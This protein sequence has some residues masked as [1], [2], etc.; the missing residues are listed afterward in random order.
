MMSVAYYIRFLRVWPFWRGR[1]RK[2]S[3]IQENTELSDVLYTSQLSEPLIL[4]LMGSKD[5]RYILCKYYTWM[6]KSEPCWEAGE[7]WPSEEEEVEDGFSWLS[8]LQGSLQRRAAMHQQ[9]DGAAVRCEDRRCSKIH[10]KS[11]IKHRR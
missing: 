3:L 2:M 7:L 6:H 4:H 1:A 11:W 5:K 10:F 9:G 8:L